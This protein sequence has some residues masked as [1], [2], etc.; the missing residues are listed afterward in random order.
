VSR[1]RAWW[2]NEAGEF[3]SRWHAGQQAV[4]D[5]DRRVVAAIAGSGGGKTHLGAPWLYREARMQPGREFIAAEP[6]W[7][8]VERVMHPALRSIVEPTGGRMYADH[9]DVDCG[10][11]HT[12]R[13]WLASADR[14]ERIEGIHAA[15]AW[16]DEAGQMPGLMLETA[17]R[18]LGKAQGRLLLTTTPY[19]LGWL[20]T[21]VYDRWRAGDPDYHVSQFA[22]TAN[23]SYPPEELERARATMPPWRFRMFM[24]GEFDRPAGLIY[25]A[26]QDAPRHEGGHLVADFHIPPGWAR[27]VGV[28]FGAVN[29]A[30]VWLAHDPERDVLYAYREYLEGGKTTGEHAGVIL[31]HGETENVVTV[32]GGSPSEN[33]PRWDYNAHAVPMRPPVVADVESGINRVY[34]LLKTNRLAVFES[35]RGLRSELG[36]YRRKLDANGQ[37]TDAIDA[38]A[39]YH[40]LDAL[41]YIAQHIGAPA[42]AGGG[43]YD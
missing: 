16:L 20:K 17:L 41:R 30:M 5:S 29:T 32:A 7:A 21:E 39:S 34:A 33:Q 13:I 24:M 27:Y 23:P 25:D 12:S 8:M 4:W 28:D 3:V 42:L 35:L 10:G 15:G 9:A 36:S 18:R 31:G 2:L 26:Y 11:G 22:S 43:M 38:K 14:P 19:D 40:R 37:P 6:T 1:T